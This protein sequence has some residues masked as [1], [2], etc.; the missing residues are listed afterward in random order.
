MDFSTPGRPV[1]STVGVTKAS[2]LVASL[3]GA[4]RVCPKR[5]KSKQQPATVRT[6]YFEM[7][8][9]L[10][11]LTNTHPLLPTV[12]HPLTMGKPTVK[13]Q[14]VTAQ[15]QLQAIRSNIM[16]SYAT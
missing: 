13:Q 12:P 16:C 3:F 4:H 6:V 9:L 1:T 5:A 10:F 15:N 7:M 8:I 2:L 11:G 14:Q